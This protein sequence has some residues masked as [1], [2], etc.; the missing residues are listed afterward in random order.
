MSQI[1][2]SQTIWFSPRP[3]HPMDP[4]RSRLNSQLW[5]S[6]IAIRFRSSRVHVQRRNNWVELPQARSLDTILVIFRLKFLNFFLFELSLKKM[7]NN[8]TLVRIRSSH[9]LWDAKMSKKAPCLPWL[10]GPR[11]VTPEYIVH[12]NIFLTVCVSLSELGPS[13]SH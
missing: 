13:E 8:N 7:K 2:W 11:V 4:W 5:T 3:L 12:K 1:R 9:H 6:S 10:W